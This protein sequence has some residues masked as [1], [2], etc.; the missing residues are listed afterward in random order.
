MFDTWPDEMGGGMFSHHETLKEWLDWLGSGGEEKK[1][2][3]AG[4]GGR[5]G[6]PFLRSDPK[7]EGYDF[8]FGCFLIMIFFASFLY[9][10]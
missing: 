4:G 7:F 1:K 3:A 5:A 8:F 9:Y 10:N 6:P 2:K